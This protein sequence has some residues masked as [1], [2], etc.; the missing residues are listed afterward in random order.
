M[1]RFEFLKAFLLDKDNLATIQVE[2][3]YE[4]LLGSLSESKEKEQFTEL[5]L[6]LIRQK[7]DGVAGG[8]AF[9]DNLIASQTGK[10]HPQSDDKEMRLYKIFDSIKSSSA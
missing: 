4:E 10:K 2:P 6:C 7:Y 9:V 1:L 8:K 5:P 3:Y